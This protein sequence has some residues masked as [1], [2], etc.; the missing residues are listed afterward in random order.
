MKREFK[1][2]SFIEDNCKEDFETCTL[3]FRKMLSLIY[4]EA[5][6][7]GVEDNNNL[8]VTAMNWHREK[9]GVEYIIH[10]AE[11]LQ[12][13]LDMYSQTHENDSFEIEINFE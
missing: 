2:K 9:Y 1:I 13:L 10:D 11:S 8:I 12:G 6:A 7:H 3:S 5:F 4:R